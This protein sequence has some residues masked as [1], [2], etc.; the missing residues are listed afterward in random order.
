MII[1]IALPQI[2]WIIGDI[3]FI[4]D[5][6]IADLP[7]S[8]WPIFISIEISDSIRISNLLLPDSRGWNPTTVT[9]I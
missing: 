5:S 3:N 1:F 8:R 9:R 6:W 4:L 7:L 2:R